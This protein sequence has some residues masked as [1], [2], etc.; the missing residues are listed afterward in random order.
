MPTIF[1][2]IKIGTHST[3]EDAEKLSKAMNRK[4]V[5]KKQKE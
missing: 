5:L 2:G 3:E 4:V 1:N